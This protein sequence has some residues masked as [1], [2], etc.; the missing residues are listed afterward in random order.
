MNLNTFLEKLEDGSLRGFTS[1]T[2]SVTEFGNS[3]MNRLNSYGHESDKARYFGAYNTARLT[4]SVGRITNFTFDIANMETYIF[5]I[6]TLRNESLNIAFVPTREI[7]IDFISESRLDEYNIFDVNIN[8]VNYYVFISSRAEIHTPS[9]TIRPQLYTI[10]ELTLIKAKLNT[11]TERMFENE[12]FASTPDNNAHVFIN[13]GTNL[14]LFL[15][16]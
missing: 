1:W 16:L 7:N 5:D 13:N 6:L 11:L 9:E 12:C 14:E 4:K 10:D 15:S 2:T 8:G 3:S